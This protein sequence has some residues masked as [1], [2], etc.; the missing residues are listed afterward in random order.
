M[1]NQTFTIDLPDS[2]ATVHVLKGTWA[3]AQK[4]DAM[5][6]DAGGLPARMAV[7]LANPDG[8]LMFTTPEDVQELSEVMTIADMNYIIEKWVE[9]VGVSKEAIR[10]MSKNYKASQ[11]GGSESA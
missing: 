4:F 3:L 9:A 2:G 8:S 6:D 11:N 5:K 10:E 1:R 7:I